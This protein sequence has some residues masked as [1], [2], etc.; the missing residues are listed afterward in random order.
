MKTLNNTLVLL[1]L[2]LSSILLFSCQE[3]D[4]DSQEGGSL[5]IQIDAHDNYT[6]VANSPSNVVF[7][8]SSNTPW[9]ITSDQQWA[10]PSPSMSASSSLVSEIVVSLES[11][12]GDESRTATLTVEADGINEAK[13]ITIIQASKENL[14]VVPYDGMVPSEGGE[15]AF[16]IISNKEWKIIPS[17]QFLENIDVVSGTGDESGEKVGIT[18]TIPENAGSRRSGSITVKTAYEEYTFT[19][20]QD[21]VVIEQAEP[22]ESGIIQ[23]GWS[24]TEKIVQVRSN[25]AWEVK[26][27]SEYSDWMEAEA[28]SES[29]LKLTVKPSNKLST[30]SAHVELSTVQLIPGFENVIFNIEQRPQYW[31]AGNQVTIDEETGNAKMMAV[32][33]NNIVSN[34]S[35]KKGRLTFD[36][37]ELNLTSTTRLVFNMWPSWGNTNFHFWLRSDAS[38]QFTSGGSGFS[39]EQKQFKISEEELNAIKRIEL[40]VE[41]DPINVDKLQLRLAIDGVDKAI[42]SNKTDPYIVDPNNNPGQIMNLQITVANPGDYYIIKSITHE[43]YE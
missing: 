10:K 36:F 12:T 11:N 34:Y 7:N 16:N 32:V 14:V 3:F 29:E 26:V 17:T 15:I 1:I 25:T 4:I 19:I 20:N 37:E 41:D 43:P 2:L 39:W 18:I 5:N 30:R 40:F 22:S 21:G 38:T 24:E 31:F 13:L 9:K 33:G 42:L 23:F 28:I 35:F 8:I 27:P 6:A